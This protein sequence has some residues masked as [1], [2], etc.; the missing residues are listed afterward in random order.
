MSYLSL[1]VYE[2]RGRRD[3]DLLFANTTMGV[4]QRRKEVGGE[5][6]NYLSLSAALFLRGSIPPLES[7]GAGTG[8]LSS[9]HHKAAATMLTTSFRHRRRLWS[10]IVLSSPPQKFTTRER[11]SLPWTT[12]IA[13]GR[14][15]TGRLRPLFSSSSCPRRLNSRVIIEIYKPRRVFFYWKKSS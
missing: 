15:T 4:T 8:F 5:V 1:L 10:K 7:R 9:I 2:L 12:S 11:S 3:R 13:S 14:K 6:T